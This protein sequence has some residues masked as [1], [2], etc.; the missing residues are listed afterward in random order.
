MVILA[1]SIKIHLLIHD[2]VE[3]VYMINS[4]KKYSLRELNKEMQSMLKENNKVNN[5]KMFVA[6]R[7][8]EKLSVTLKPVPNYDNQYHGLHPKFDETML[9]AFL[10]KLVNNSASEFWKA[11]ELLQKQDTCLMNLIIP[12]VELS[13]V[14]VQ[15]EK[16]NE[17]SLDE[18]YLKNL[19]NNKDCM[20]ELEVS[21]LGRVILQ[22]S[23]HYGY[24]FHSMNKY[25]YENI[26]SVLEG[27]PEALATCFECDDV[28]LEVKF[29]GILPQMYIEKI[30]DKY[31]VTYEES[32]LFIDLKENSL[33][34]N[35]LY[36]LLSFKG[37]WKE[38]HK[39]LTSDVYYS[40]VMPCVRKIDYEVDPSYSNKVKYIIF[41]VVRTTFATV[42]LMD[43][44]KVLNHPFFILDKG[45]EHQN[46]MYQFDHYEDYLQSKYLYSGHG[47][48]GDDCAD[49][50][51]NMIDGLNQYLKHSFNTHTIA[52]SANL[53]TDDGY[54]ITGKRGAKN[55]DS[56]ELYCSANGQSEF[57]DENV[58]FYRKS[59][60]EDMP[61]MEYG[62]KYRIDLK[63]EIERE[64]I[65]ELGIYST[66]PDWKY[67]GISYLS[68]NNQVSVTSDGLE[69]SK[70]VQFRR[71]HFNVLTSNTL[72]L[73]FKEVLKTHQQATENF[74]NEM[75]IGIKTKVV[76]SI[77]G[78]AKELFEKSYN[79]LQRNY[80]N[81][82]IIALIIYMVIG[83]QKSKID[84][85]NFYFEF[86]LLV[87]SIGMWIY[88]WYRNRDTRGKTYNK[89]FYLPRHYKNGR[90][91]MSSVLTTLSKNVIASKSF[92][93]NT[94][95]NNN[96]KLHAIFRVMYILHFIE[97]VEENEGQEKSKP[98][99]SSD[100]LQ[101]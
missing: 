32:K 2:E 94:K 56:G 38:H 60:F 24:C 42:D 70:S 74:E 30:C 34:N 7:A 3:N 33:N 49:Y 18:D 13:D 54:L 48:I 20:S 10:H 31:Y 66:S 78:L 62:S 35:E 22:M 93:R 84:D 89:F 81:V 68:I 19:V 29:F 44:T 64:S 12:D 71:M 100:H 88:N 51:K 82:T 36:E 8:D 97:L 46:R 87:I 61:T 43:N 52:V 73:S 17:N 72:P 1:C 95:K 77:W 65:A 9:K 92:N 86:L 45:I 79:W 57:C 75:L 67:Y 11:V 15:D 58:E 14:K 25:V 63:S 6:T 26:K 99:K 5:L 59:V 69:E 85:L 27:L 47:N 50:E 37:D 96:Y 83:K 41:R 76:N 4:L 90:L 53:L 21:L 40:G 80:T 98:V 39:L 91:V 28:T 23:S 16:S 55:I 101:T